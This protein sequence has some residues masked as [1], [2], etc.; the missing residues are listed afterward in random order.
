[1]Q[2]AIE[3]MLRETYPLAVIW[4]RQAMA[5]IDGLRVWYVYRDGSFLSAETMDA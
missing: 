3:A 1:M 2:A 5:S 4:P